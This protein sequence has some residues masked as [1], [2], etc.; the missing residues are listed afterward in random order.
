MLGQAKDT[1]I[2]SFWADAVV[3]EEKVLDAERSDG[4]L[5]D[6]LAF[7]GESFA[8]AAGSSGKD[9]FLSLFVHHA[10]E[11]VVLSRED[12]SAHALWRR[13]TMLYERVLSAGAWEEVEQLLFQLAEPADAEP[14]VVRHMGP[15]LACAL[16]DTLRARLQAVPQPPPPSVFV[17]QDLLDYAGR[18]AAR[19][20]VEPAVD[21]A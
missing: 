15:Q 9:H 8:V 14:K 19:I 18:F 20:V 11:T 2:G 3:T 1:V 7:A 10:V 4:L 6:L 16:L 12:P 21:G 5:R 17:T 13:I